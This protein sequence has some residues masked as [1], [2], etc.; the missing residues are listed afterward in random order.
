MDKKKLLKY[1]I[2]YLSKYDSSKNNLVNILRRKIFRL[3]ISGL[4]KKLLIDEIENIIL[5]LKENNLINDRRYS[6]SK[7]DL[8]ARAGK[9]K[10]FI[11][12]Y[13]IKKGIDKNELNND[14]KNFHENNTDW[15]LNAAELFA[16]KK[17]IAKK[18]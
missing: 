16:K 2:D 4:E 17:K 3:K 7:I 6:S 15:E 1:A 8:L 14:L 18:Q 12:N 5:K 13:L 11:L 10:N 9:S